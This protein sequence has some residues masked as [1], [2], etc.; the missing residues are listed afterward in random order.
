[1]A[2]SPTRCDAVTEPATAPPPVAIRVENLTK[3][4][5]AIGGPWQRV[6]E[7]LRPG[8]GRGAREFTALD[9]VSFTVPRGGALGVVGA[10]GAG[11]STLLKALAGIVE[12]TEGRIE[13]AGSVGSIIELGTGFHP[14][15]TGR[16][17][18]FLNALGSRLSGRAREAD[19]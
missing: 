2:V 19:V 14:E 15:F 5:R 16:E 17:N 4:Y 18:V 12:P 3:R 9:G 1:M 8:S 13:L 10:N 6:R 7:L 11:K